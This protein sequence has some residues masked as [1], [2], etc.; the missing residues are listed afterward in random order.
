M[1]RRL[2]RLLAVPEYRAMTGVWP[3]VAVPV[4]DA[5]LDDYEREFTERL[6]LLAP[7]VLEN[8][9]PVVE[10]VCMACGAQESRGPWHQASRWV[11]RGGLPVRRATFYLCH[12]HRD[13]P[14]VEGIVVSTNLTDARRMQ[15][16]LDELPAAGANLLQRVERWSPDE[17]K[18][19]P[20]SLDFEMF[21]TRDQAA[22]D[23]LAFWKATPEGL[24]AKAAWLGPVRKDYRL[25][26]RL[27]LVRDYG[28][29]RREMFI[30]VRLGVNRFA[31]YRTDS[32]TGAQP[33]RA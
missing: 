31:T 30:V 17:D 2:R 7:Q 24:A 29:G 27:D 22:D 18:P 21:R 20:E 8:D 3:W 15:A 13:V 6:R 1:F 5:C 9:E 23:A 10:K 33:A 16:V 28:T 26:Y 25:R 14:Y 32:P 12:P 19:P 11:G 4:C